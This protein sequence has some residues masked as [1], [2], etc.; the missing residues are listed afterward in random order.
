M[1]FEI[2]FIETFSKYN[3]NKIKNVV[4]GIAAISPPILSLSFAISVIATIKNA[5]IKIF[6]KT[7]DMMY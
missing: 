4:I 1:W 3:Q 7:K 6:N 2:L 5:V